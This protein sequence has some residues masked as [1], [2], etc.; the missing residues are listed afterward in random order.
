MAASFMR[1]AITA[2]VVGVATA[3]LP[4]LGGTVLVVR[5]VSVPWIS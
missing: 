1:F 3:Q 5:I 4:L 2:V